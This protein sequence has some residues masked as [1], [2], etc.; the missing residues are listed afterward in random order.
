MLSILSS[1]FNQTFNSNNKDNQD[2]SKNYMKYPNNYLDNINVPNQ[3]NNM[4]EPYKNIIPNQF[5]NQPYTNQIPNQITNINDP[6]NP[7]KTILNNLNQYPQNE[8]NNPL[9]NTLN[10]NNNYT[11]EP[12][13]PY[14]NAPQSNNIEL[15][16]QKKNPKFLSSSIPYIQNYLK[17]NIINN[18]NLNTP[19][20]QIQ[21]R[22]NHSSSPNQNEKYRKLSPSNPYNKLKSNRTGSG[23]REKKYNK[24][25]Y[26]PDGT[27]WACDVGCSISTTGY[28]PMT[29]SPYV[30]NVKR[31]DVT[32]VKPGTR[33]EEYTRHKKKKH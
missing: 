9:S 19:Y 30:N 22:K 4:N 20:N 27:C 33:Y 18:N 26:Y 10:S 28:S 12:N 3:F 11:N 29:F 5:N 21:E 7:N 13:I 1:P 17:D 31:R 2:P 6:L 8:N 15:N 25:I 32:P 14:T 23:S 24:I 16:E